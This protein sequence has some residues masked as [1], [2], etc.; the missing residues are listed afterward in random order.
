MQ[1][2]MFFVYMHFFDHYSYGI[3]AALEQINANSEKEFVFRS[4]MFFNSVT[5]LYSKEND[6]YEV[7]VAEQNVHNTLVLNFVLNVFYN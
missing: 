3:K 2:I 1:R 7:K 4:K 6:S 5:F